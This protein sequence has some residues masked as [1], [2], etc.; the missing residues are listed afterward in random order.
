MAV[1]IYLIIGL[2]DIK[3][4]GVTLLSCV[5]SM[6]MNVHICICMSAW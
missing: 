1:S 4:C 2:F 5:L 6:Y 3:P